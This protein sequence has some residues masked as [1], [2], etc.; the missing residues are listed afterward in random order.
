MKY[1]SSLCQADNAILIAID[2]QPKVFQHTIEWEDVKGL[3]IKMLKL[4][5]L[6]Q[7]PTIVCEQYP[8]GLG[9][10][11]SDM[12][13]VFEAMTSDKAVFP[14]LS[15]GS[16][17]E[18][19]FLA[20]LSEKASIIKKNRKDLPEDAPVDLIIMGIESHICVL[21]TSLELLQV[22]GYRLVLADDCITGRS[23]RRHHL[24]MS[25]LQQEGAI[26]SN[27]ESIAFEWTRRKD[28]A[29]FKKMSQLIRE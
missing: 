22:K 7:V 4:A 1:S 18:N 17:G 23:I 24:A 5:D 6:F 27:F 15:F 20:L 12:L 26:I 3:A 25:R 8:Q 10:T 14:K 13:A 29:N 2:F 28:H 16:C 9:H 21:Q 19:N 11:D